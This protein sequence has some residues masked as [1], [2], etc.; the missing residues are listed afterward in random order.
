[1]FSKMRKRIILYVLFK[2]EQIVYF[3][4]SYGRIISQ[5]I[6]RIVSMFEGD[7]LMANIDT[8]IDSSDF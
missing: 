8:L 4:K 7:K 6:M 5:Q 2:C 1:M 3:S